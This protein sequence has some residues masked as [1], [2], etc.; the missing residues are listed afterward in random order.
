MLENLQL[1]W[2]WWDVLVWVN[3]EDVRKTN[4]DPV[5]FDGWSRELFVQALE[6]D[7]GI[8]TIMKV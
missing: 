5:V 8:V 7:V 6:I 1:R 4:I 3:T 2:H